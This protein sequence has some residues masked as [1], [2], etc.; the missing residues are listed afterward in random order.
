MAVY[1][2]ITDAE[3][4]AYLAD[5]DLGN[6]LSFKGIAEGV[7]N[8]NFM[9]ETEGGR[10]ILTV[11]ERRVR[12]GDLPFFLGLMQW[13]A[14]RGYP[15]ATPIADRSGQVL[16]TLRGKP[17]AIVGFLPGLSARRPSVANCREAGAGLGWLHVAA[18]GFP[19][20]RRNALGQ[21]AWAAIFAP[22]AGAANTLKPGLAKIVAADLARF[23]AHWP[24]DLPLGIIHADYF[25]DN[26]FFADGRFA[27]AIDFYFAARDTLAYDIAVALNAWCFEADDAFNLALSAAFLEGYQTRRTL[28]AA[29]KAALPLLAHGAA[30]RFFLTRLH[31]WGA[32]PAGSLVRPKDPLEYERKLAVHRGGLTLF[33]PAS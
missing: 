2:D 13:L 12:A 33:G 3:L 11:Y 7:E 14:S 26:V 31:D 24:R 27:G 17:A 18:A 22:L 15:S 30:M 28:N 19:G 8:S 25:P 6:P 20:R 32:T 29:E 16:K 5:F 1:T 10:Y 23:E 21:G 9:L 4:A